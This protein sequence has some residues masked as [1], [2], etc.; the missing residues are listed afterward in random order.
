MCVVHNELAC[1]DSRWGALTVI[2]HCGNHPHNVSFTHSARSSLSFGALTLK[3]EPQNN[4]RADKSPRK[5][6]CPCFDLDHKKRQRLMKTQKR[7]NSIDTFDKE[8][9]RE[10]RFLFISTIL[11]VNLKYLEFN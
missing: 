5:S 3:K 8:V 9:I 7:S 4:T 11:Y 1:N 6:K 2:A 10:K